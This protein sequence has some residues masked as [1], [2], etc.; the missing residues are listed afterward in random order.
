MSDPVYKT[1]QP[2]EKYYLA[3][4]LSMSEDE[5]NTASYLK[6]P[7]TPFFTTY[8]AAEAF[9]DNTIMA[10]PENR[11]FY[12]VKTRDSNESGNFYHDSIVII[13]RLDIIPHK[14]KVRGNANSYMYAPTVN[15][16]P[17]VEY[18]YSPSDTDQGVKYL[19]LPV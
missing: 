15:P 3:S 14:P 2:L 18:Q 6:I 7:N 13:R 10:S 17:D 5:W 4:Q 11:K 9:Y 16:L 1:F 19:I 12:R 8:A